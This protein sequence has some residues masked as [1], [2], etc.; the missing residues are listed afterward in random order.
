MERL[1]AVAFLFMSF[2]SNAVEHRRAD[3]VLT[4][5]TQDKNGFIYFAGHQ[6]LTRF[7]G[8][9][10]QSMDDLFDL[11]SSWIRAI[12]ITPDGLLLITSQD[13]GLWIADPKTYTSY[14]FLNYEHKAAVA[15]EHSIYVA[16]GDRVVH[17]DRK[18]GSKQTELLK[19]HRIGQFVYADRRVYAATDKGIYRFERHK[20]Y[21][22][23]E[24]DYRRL[25][26]VASGLMAVGPKGVTHFDTH[27]GEAKHFVKEGVNDVIRADPGYVWLV[28]HGRLDLVG[29]DNLKV[30]RSDVLRKKI[31]RQ[32]LFT[33]SEGSLWVHTIDDIYVVPRT[34]TTIE[35]PSTERS[36]EITLG[37]FG[38][39]KI[40][41]VT[42]DQFY[43]ID[44]YQLTPF[45]T[46]VA[47]DTLVNVLIEFNGRLLV[48]SNRGVQYSDSTDLKA[49]GW[50]LD[51]DVIDG[52]IYVST[53]RDGFYILDSELNV[54]EHYT[55]KNGLADNEVMSIQEIE[56]LV[57]VTTSTSFHKL[58]KGIIQPV[59]GP[60]VLG[61]FAGLA[62]KDGL[63]FAASYGG[64]VWVQ[65]NSTWRKVASP[66]GVHSM[67]VYNNAIYVSARDGLCV[68]RQVDCMPIPSVKNYVFSP[69]A[70]IYDGKHLYVG[71]MKGVTVINAIA[72]AS[73]EK[74]FML[75]WLE[76]DGVKQ[77]IL[78]G[79]IEVQNDQ[80]VSVGVSNNLMVAPLTYWR[81]AIANYDSTSEY[82]QMKDTEIVLSKLAPGKNRL[83]VSY[84]NSDGNWS[85]D[86]ELL[87]I[88]VKE[89]WYTR[90]TAI[91]S[92]VGAAILLI[93]AVFVIAFGVIRM[94]RKQIL[95]LE[96]ASL[97]HK[98]HD[99]LTVAAQLHTVLNEG[100][101]DSGSAYELSDRLV[102]ELVPISLTKGA[103]GDKTLHNGLHTLC[104]INHRP[105]L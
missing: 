72:L 53:D 77:R 48:G 99:I 62:F 9:R 95:H 83:L 43:V 58:S 1:I 12:N 23:V 73:P 50:V 96:N 87:T 64:G 97:D 60:K 6:G 49:F 34:V 46:K 8:Q 90:T 61:K 47:K 22:I 27:T 42:G 105:S 93:T 71:G 26:S 10:Y 24:G 70:M 55:T 94:Q 29:I 16:L 59:D 20:A 66:N 35:N 98:V 89:V 7:D 28:Q 68:I 4:G 25:T 19:G 74:D 5:M 54:L 101:I 17:S 2:I 36:P 88:D 39:N 63:L 33:D 100:D 103:L 3:Q 67:N 21:K 91:L 85:E 52:K 18:L 82:R 41:A 102:N 75:S 15:D 81:F 40:A 45:A 78:S 69:N 32:S 11:K 80:L 92:Y 38:D 84:Q 79:N 30:Y 31:N 76:V 104:H 57:W 14:Q 86:K 51:V 13:N 37:L 56:G 65:D 44:D